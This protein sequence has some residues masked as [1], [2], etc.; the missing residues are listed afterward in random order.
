MVVGVFIGRVVAAGEAWPGV[1]VARSVSLEHFQS[2][3][4][5]VFIPLFFDT[6]PF[7]SVF[8]AGLKFQISNWPLAG[9]SPPASAALALR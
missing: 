3:S 4:A 8:Q 7:C 5:N 2:R 6:E 1:T 9:G